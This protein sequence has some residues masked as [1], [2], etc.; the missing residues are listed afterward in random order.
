MANR[1]PLQ[2]GDVAP[3]LSDY[4]FSNEADRRADQVVH[5]VRSNPHNYHGDYPAADQGQPE[6]GRLW[7]V[8]QATPT[9]AAP[10]PVVLMDGD[11]NGNPAE[12]HELSIREY[13]DCYDPT[14][15]MKVRTVAPSESH[16]DVDSDGD[17]YR[18]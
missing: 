16:W 1:Y 17:G 14:S 8:G 9:Q 18:N 13:G 6:S 4:N 2:P 12:V 3:D 15:P 11:N 10:W 5:A 7:K